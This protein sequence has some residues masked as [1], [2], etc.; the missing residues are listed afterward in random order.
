MYEMSENQ[1]NDMKIA[2]Y[3]INQDITVVNTSLNLNINLFQCINIRSFKCS[4]CAL[5]R[6][7]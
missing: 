5:Q 4:I 2:S 7:N 3:E 6:L 1:T